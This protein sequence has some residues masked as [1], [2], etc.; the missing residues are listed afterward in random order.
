[1]AADTIDPYSHHIEFMRR[2]S[3]FYRLF[4]Q[5]PQLL[6]QLLD[7]PPANPETYR[8]DS[9]SIKEPTFAIDGVFLPPETQGPG[10]VYFVEVQFQK[11]QRLYERLFSEAFLYFYRNRERFSDWQ[12]V[13]IYPNRATEQTDIRPYEGLLNSPQVHRIYLNELGDIQTLPPE[14]ALMVLTTLPEKT[15]SPQAKSLVQRALQGD[16]PESR[17]RAIIEMIITI[18]VYKFTHLNHNEVR[19]MLGI[20]DVSLKDTRFYQEAK[21]DG[22]QSLLL[23]LLT[24]KCGPLSDDLNVAI[25]LLAPA[26]I[27]SLAL[28]LLNFSQ[29]SDLDTWLQPELNRALITALTQKLG[30]LPETILSALQRPTSSPQTLTPLDRSIALAQSWTELNT[31]TALQQWLDDHY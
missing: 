13:L 19:A 5:S 4:A 15:I 18:L 2:D 3:I 24:Q 10:I 7:H 20:T 1:L 22:L 14:V 11:D 8:F 28:A 27:Q 6:F 9:V 30:E 16:L 31:L 23:L 12:A 25:Q 29:R 17:Q 21:E 26:Q